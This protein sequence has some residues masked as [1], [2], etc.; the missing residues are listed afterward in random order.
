[1]INSLAEA[2]PATPLLDRVHSALDSSPYLA[3]G[4]VRIEAEHGQVRLLGK[5]K[6]YFEKQM[7]QE[8]LRRIDGVQQI[9]NQLEVN[10]N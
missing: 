9:E 5:V 8:V 2:A 10:W 1:M 6:S 7:A 4:G 3:G